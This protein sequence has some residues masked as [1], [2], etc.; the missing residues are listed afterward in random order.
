MGIALFILPRALAILR[1]SVHVL[2]E[3]APD[4]VDVS[5]LRSRL[6]EIPGVEEVHDLHAWTLTSG[7]H[8]VSV[9]VRA[10]QDTPRGQVLRSV[11]RLLKRSPET[12]H[13][14][15]QVERGK[16]ID[17]ESIHV[18]RRDPPAGEAEKEGSP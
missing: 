12:D 5:E 9:H 7:F 14:T 8:S 13:A 3:A 15:V 4:D 16:E 1:R 17:C 18:D 6:L 10:G 11:L 2:L